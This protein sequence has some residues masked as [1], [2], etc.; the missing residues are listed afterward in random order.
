MDTQ[1]PEDRI[2][3]ENQEGLE[4]SGS[5]NERIPKLLIYK[6]HERC[7]PDMWLVQNWQG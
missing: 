6:R 1:E 3:A 5:R 7:F 2:T 4:E